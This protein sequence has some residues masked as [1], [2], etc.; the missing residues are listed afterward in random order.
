MAAF[1][2]QGGRS[3]PEAAFR[4]VRRARWDVEVA[5]IVGDYTE[6]RKKIQKC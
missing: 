5:G 6:L 4:D 2:H 3:G 1:R